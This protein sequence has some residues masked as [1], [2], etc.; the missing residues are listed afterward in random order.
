MIWWFGC[1]IKSLRCQYSESN[2]D[3]VVYH[4]VE[5]DDVD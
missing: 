5:N 2:L 4:D 3:L 1:E